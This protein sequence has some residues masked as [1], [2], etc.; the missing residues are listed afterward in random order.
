MLP[1]GGFASADKIAAVIQHLLS[2]DASFTNALIYMVDG[3][4]TAGLYLGDGGQRK[5]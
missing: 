3:G 4:E 1:P 2:P 5:P